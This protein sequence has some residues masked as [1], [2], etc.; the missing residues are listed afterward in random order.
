MSS[1]ILG[2]A[3]IST[4]SSTSSR[5]SSSEA[6]PRMARCSHLA[7]VDLAGF[8]GEAGADVLRRGGQHPGDLAHQIAIARRRLV[9]WHRD[10][11]TRAHGDIG[12]HDR[13]ADLAAVALGAGELPGGNLR[14]I[15]RA[16]GEP[17]LELVPMRALQ[18]VLDHDATSSGGVSAAYTTSN[19]RSCC[20][21]GTWRR[22]SSNRCNSTSANVTAG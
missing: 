12:R 20:R 8:L 2:S 19:G 6:V 18:A 15:G 9:V 13:L 14:V 1:G 16:R 17:T 11:R 3:M 10:V 4:P 22:T 21:D 7:I 5:A